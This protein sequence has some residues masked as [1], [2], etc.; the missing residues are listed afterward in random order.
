MTLSFGVLIG[1]LDEKKGRGSVR[2]RSIFV[3]A[4]DRQHAPCASRVSWV[5]RRAVHGAVIVVDLEKEPVTG[6]IDRAEVVFAVWIILWLEGVV[7]S[8]GR[9]QGQA[10]ILGEGVNA[11]CDHDCALDEGL[12]QLIV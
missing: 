10:L 8:D 6:E 11:G 9:Q 4:H 1:D 3:S 7:G 2:G 5:R 12:S